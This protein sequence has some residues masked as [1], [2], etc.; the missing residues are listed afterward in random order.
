MMSKR[1]AFLT[2][3]L[4]SLLVVTAVLA[5]MLLLWYPQ[6]YFL[7]FDARG[8]LQVLVGVDLVLGPALTLVV[9]KP[10]KSGLWFDMSCIAALQL[11]ALVYGTTVIYQQRPY[12]VVFAAD[13]F[14]ILARGEID[15]TQLRSPEL[16]RKPWGQPIL[17]VARLPDDPLARKQLIE[18][19]LFEGK[20]DIERRPALWEPYSDALELV[21]DRARPLAELAELRPAAATAVSAAAAR[22]AGPLSYVPVMGKTRAYALVLAPA[23]LRPVDIIDA[24]PFGGPG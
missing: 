18:E 10:G 7:A 8:I 9:Y 19:T 14:E 5:L 23:T 2:H 3:L 17:A 13:R 1:K 20:P 4:L 22:H 16:R 12:F 24:D 6:P 15:A 21:R 11:A